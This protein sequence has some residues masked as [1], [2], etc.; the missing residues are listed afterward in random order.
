MVVEKTTGAPVLVSTGAAARALGIDRSTLTRWA[1]SGLVT[2]ANKTAGG[3]MR[4]NLVRLQAQL[5]ALSSEG[6]D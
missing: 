4:W 3:H 5:D 1:A 2:P 6:E